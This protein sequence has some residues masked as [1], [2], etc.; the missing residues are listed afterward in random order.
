[1]AQSFRSAD[2]EH[3][4]EKAGEMTPAQKITVPALPKI[5]KRRLDVLLKRVLPPSYNS[6]PRRY[7]RAI[8]VLRHVRYEIPGREHEFVYTEDRARECLAF[9]SS[10]IMQAG[11]HLRLLAE[12]QTAARSDSARDASRKWSA[13]RCRDA[14][15]KFRQRKTSALS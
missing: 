1:M 13:T 10:G 2:Q 12:A 7:A 5:E 4:E 15:G 6:F 11:N 3:T 9:Y 14:R 8:E